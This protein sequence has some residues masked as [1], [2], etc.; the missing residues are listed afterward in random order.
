MMKQHPETREGEMYL[1]NCY[2]MGRP[3]INSLGVE[4]LGGSF[5]SDFEAI[6]W[7]TKRA[8]THAYDSNDAI[9]PGGIPVFVQISEYNGEAD[10]ECQNV[11]GFYE[12][13][14]HKFI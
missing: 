3:V 12:M 6:K 5:G 8:G 4:S 9:V 7:K 2:P 14:R 1:T 13:I 10:S 11:R